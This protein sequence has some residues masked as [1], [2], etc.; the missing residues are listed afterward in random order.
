MAK[1]KNRSMWKRWI[2]ALRSGR[3]KQGE[4][5]LYNNTTHGYCCLGVLARL[6]GASNR[7]L[8]RMEAICH[9]RINELVSMKT[10]RKLAF[11]NDGTGPTVRA[12]KPESFA[13]I[14]TYIERYM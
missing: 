10:R 6:Q 12:R 1:M 2:D 3:Y 4:S 7:S 5:M 8:D 11:M 13:Q 9:P 14:A